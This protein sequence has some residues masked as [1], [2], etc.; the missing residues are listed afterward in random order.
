MFFVPFS[1]IVVSTSDWSISSEVLFHQYFPFYFEQCLREFPQHFTCSFK[2]YNFFCSLKSN[3][4][5]VAQ[6]LF[7]IA[8]TIIRD[9]LGSIIMAITHKLI[10]SDARIGEAFVALLTIRLTASFGC[11]ILF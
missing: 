10:S 9:A 6:G 2:R 11:N 5:V 7:V 4:D 3:F 1:M 8:D